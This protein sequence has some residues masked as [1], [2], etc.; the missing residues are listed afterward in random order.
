MKL[1]INDLKD[2]EITKVKP[3]AIYFNYKDNKYLLHESGDCGEYG[4]DLFKRTII[5]NGSQKL[6]CIVGIFG[7]IPNCI[8]YKTQKGN[9]YNQ[10]DME[11]FVLKL[12][13]EGFFSG[14]FEDNIKIVER[15]NKAINDE[16]AK[17]QK[18]INKLRSQ[19]V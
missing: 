1:E 5:E 4:T 3:W 17:L 12:T 6:E 10:I 19:L 16:I 13:K 15:N 9:T 8:R 2:I 18:E 11:Y 14:I 7:H